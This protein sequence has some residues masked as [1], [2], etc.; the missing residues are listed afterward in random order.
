MLRRTVARRMK[1]ADLELVTRGEFPHGMKEPQ[2]IKKSDQN[3]PWYFSTVRTTYVWPV[4]GD[5]W[6]DLGEEDKHH[7]LH[8]FY[9]LA[10]WKLG[11]GIYDDGP[12]DK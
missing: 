3:I 8:M 2:W 11:E 12:Q 5:N 1:Y 4:L 6:S 7:D 9:T 10:W